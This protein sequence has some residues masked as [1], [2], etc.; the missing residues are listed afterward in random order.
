M[1]HSRCL[2]HRRHL[3][4]TL[5]WLIR[6]R[7]P[8]RCCRRHG[9]EKRLGRHCLVGTSLG[10]S[11]LRWISSSDSRLLLLH[12]SLHHLLMLLRTSSVRSA[13]L[14]WLLHHLVAGLLTLRRRRM[15]HVLIVLSR[16][17]HCCSRCRGRRRLPRIRRRRCTSQRGGLRGGCPFSCFRFDFSR[18]G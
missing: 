15:L 4:H 11:C 6:L 5:H 17:G 9:V 3:L 14:L 8:T 18:S 7:S 13:W 2:T 16:R 10:W 12:H 1:G